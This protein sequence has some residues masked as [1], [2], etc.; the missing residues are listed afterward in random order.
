VNETIR[1]VGGMTRTQ[2][3]G[4]VSFV[5]GCLVSQRPRQGKKKAAVAAGA[6]GAKRTASANDPATYDAYTDFRC[7]VQALRPHQV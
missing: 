2:E 6:G 1:F 3:S 5:S 7:R 4:F